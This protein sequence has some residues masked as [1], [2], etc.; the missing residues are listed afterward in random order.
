MA[1]TK[2]QKKVYYNNRYITAV[3]I[4][5]GLVYAAKNKGHCGDDHQCRH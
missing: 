3:I 1:M 2:E 4:K 5:E